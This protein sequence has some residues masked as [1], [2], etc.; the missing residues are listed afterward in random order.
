MSASPTTTD[1]WIDYVGHHVAKLAGT[2]YVGQSDVDRDQSQNDGK[3]PMDVVRDIV[4]P[5]RNSGSWLVD[6]PTGPKRTLTL[7]TSEVP[8]DLD[9]GDEVFLEFP[10]TGPSELKHAILFGRT[11]LL[12]RLDTTLT[13]FERANP[14]EW[15]DRPLPKYIFRMED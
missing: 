15:S 10:L 12:E 2:E 11:D 3:T 6:A 14:P 1:E 4:Q 7:R 9:V 13:F 5:E 8:E